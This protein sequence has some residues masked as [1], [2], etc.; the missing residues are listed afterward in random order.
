M[1]PSP[2]LEQNGARPVEPRGTLNDAIAIAAIV[3]KGQLDKAGD[4]YILHP[5]RMM[6]RMNDETSRIV[7]VLHDVVE[8]SPE[9]DKWDFERLRTNGFSEEVI[10]AVNCVTDRK[11]QGETYEE[12]VERAASNRIARQVKIA[13]LEDNMNML[14]LG[15]VGE[16]QLDRLARYH[17]SWLYLMEQT[18]GQ[19]QG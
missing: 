5:L 12:F 11:D 4:A 9:E 16:K 3:H 6:M 8:D 7:A 15:S 2:E 14:R 17:R 10:A 13:D 19:P 1:A 18:D